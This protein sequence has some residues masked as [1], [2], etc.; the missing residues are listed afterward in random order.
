MARKLRR[1]LLSTLIIVGEGIHEKAFL[2]YLKSLYSANTNQKVKV[3]SADGGS[4]ED[5]VRTA[6]K[7]SKGIAYDKKFI[8][9]DSD[10]EINDKTKKL[11]KENN[12]TLILSEPLCL[13]GMLLRLLNI[14]VPDSSKKCK[15]LLHPKLDGK[16]TDRKSYENLITK[17]ILENSKIEQI[18]LIIKILSNK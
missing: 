16:P 9:M 17:E 13:E 7:K 6:V 4:P 5:I 18:V 2:S 1:A 10:I 15:A 3:D 11:A 14:S 8:L 12:I